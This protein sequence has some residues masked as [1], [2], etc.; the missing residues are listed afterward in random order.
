MPKRGWPM[1]IRG[2]FAAVC[3]GN[4]EGLQGDVSII[5]ESQRWGQQSDIPAPPARGQT[6]P[7]GPVSS[8]LQL[9]REQP[10]SSIFRSFLLQRLEAGGHLPRAELLGGLFADPFLPVLGDNRGP[11]RASFPALRGPAIPGAQRELQPGSVSHLFPSREKK[12]HITF[13]FANFRV[14]SLSS[15]HKRA[16]SGSCLQG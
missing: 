10:S 14:C 5:P 11:Q 16:R 8:G 9:W 2:N 1:S 7:R 3:G 15:R 12:C 4:L 6:S 13:L